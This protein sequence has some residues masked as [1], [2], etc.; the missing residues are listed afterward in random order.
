MSATPP[1]QF[2][3]DGG[4][5]DPS[6]IYMRLA[7][8]IR[9]HVREGRL[10]EG[11]ALPPERDLAEMTGVSRVTVRKAMELLMREGLLSRKQGSGTF[12]APRIQQ[13]SAALVGFS[14]DMLNRQ[15]RPGSQWIERRTCTPSP[16]EVLALGLPV[17]ARVHR[18]AR[19]RSA[20]GEP[21]AIERAT[22]PE[23]FLP[24]LA[25]VD[26]SLY[27]ALDAVGHKPASG[28]QRIT[29]SLATPEE[30]ALLG[31]P[32]G[33]AILRI[34]RR[35]YLADGR[36]V[37]FTRSAYRGDRYDFVSELR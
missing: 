7:R 10:A 3:L 28:L 14:A 1:L 33:A 27:A 25:S 16:E 17:N 32:A 35:G 22:I 30:A 26:Q 13:H 11:D 9:N 4:R 8:S 19:I 29:A 37:E 31:I 23:A 15:L 2:D 36:A 34:E 21:L 5:D 20:D 12:V 18:L 6:P 24:D